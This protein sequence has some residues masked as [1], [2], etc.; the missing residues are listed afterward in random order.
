MDNI[1][2]KANDICWG[3]LILVNSDFPMLI[4]EPSDLTAVSDSEIKLCREAA[5][6][7]DS[8]MRKISG[9]SGITPVSG[10]R[11]FEEQQNI[12]ND[13]LEESGIDFTQKYVAKPACSEHQTGL[14][15]DLGR[16]QQYID[17]VRPEFPD[18]G[19]CG[20]FKSIAAEFG[21]IL[22]YPLGKEHITKIAYEPWHFRYVGVPHAEIILKNGLVLEEYIEFLK[23][24]KYTNKPLIY[25]NAER[26]FEI[27]YLEAGNYSLELNEPFHV[28]GNNSDGFI[29]TKLGK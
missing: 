17:F 22:R 28:S 2:L 24:F 13:C 25:Q 12:W 11:S 23:Q 5:A 29:V 3:S 27:S 18:D 4:K 6:Q 16:T 19:V 7:L 10:Y 9:W 8:A 21:F 1:F 14:A 15:I 26:T 20:E